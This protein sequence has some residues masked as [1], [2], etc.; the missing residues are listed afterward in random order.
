[1]IGIGT[2]V[3]ERQH[4]DGFVN[5]GSARGSAGQFRQLQTSA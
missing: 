4:R 3:R 2:E 1:M 5:A